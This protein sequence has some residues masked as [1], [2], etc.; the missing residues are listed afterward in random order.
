MRFATDR[1]GLPLLN[2]DTSWLDAYLAREAKTLGSIIPDFDADVFLNERR[3]LY[4]LVIEETSMVDLF[5]LAL[6]FR[7]IEVHLPTLTKRVI[8]VGDENQLPPIGCGKPLQDI[9]GYLRGEPALEAANHVRL[10]ANC[11][12]QHL[13]RRYWTRRVS[14]PDAYETPRSLISRTASSLNSRVN[15][16]PSIMHLQLHQNI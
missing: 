4:H 8:L 15:F 5:Q 7:A 16:R 10:V 14:S 9:L 12:Q 2:A 13:T 11:R 1:I 6:V 3:R